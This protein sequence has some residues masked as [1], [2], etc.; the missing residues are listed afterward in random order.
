MMVLGVLLQVL[1][2]LTDALAEDRNL[3]LGRTRVRVVDFVLRD[4]AALDF[5]FDCQTEGSLYG[6]EREFLA[7]AALPAESPRIR[8]PGPVRPSRPAAAARARTAPRRRSGPALRIG[9]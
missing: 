5:S 6:S 8:A 4:Q 1:S 7:G 3:H 2:E 9:P